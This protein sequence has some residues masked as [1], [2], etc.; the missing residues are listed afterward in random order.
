MSAPKP[1]PWRK[2]LLSAV[3]IGSLWGFIG[4]CQM[5]YEYNILLNYQVL[6]DHFSLAILFQSVVIPIIIAGLLV[7]FFLMHRINNWLRRYPYWKALLFVFLSFSALYLGINLLA[8]MLYNMLHL[9]AGMTDKAVWHN[10]YLYFTGIENLKNY[11]FWS[12]INLLTILSLQI[13]NKYGPGNFRAFLLGKYFQPTR[14]E[15]IFMFLDIR[16]STLI[17]EQL[18][19]LPFFE[20]IKDFYKDATEGILRYKGEIDQYIGDEILVSWPLSVGL[21]NCNCLRSFFAIQEHFRA[22]ASHYQKRYGLVPEFKAGLHSGSAIVGEIGVIKKDIAFSGEVLNIASRIQSQC[23]DLGVDLLLSGM[24]LRQLNLPL[25][26]QTECKGEVKLRG[27]AS[28]VE[29]WT[30]KAWS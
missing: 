16:S 19:E 12:V 7:G 2:Y 24:L 10:V 20:F 6:P 13:N 3:E 28:P 29:L 22:Q 8:A 23:N 17:A 1:H 14:E 15:R 26:W 18:D 9:N 25:H 4:T 30:V 11:T 21:E 27:K 5:F